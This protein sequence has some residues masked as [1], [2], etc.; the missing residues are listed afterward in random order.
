MSENLVMLICARRRGRKQAPVP[1]SQV[2]RCCECGSEVFVSP[3]SV[4]ILAK[5]HARPLCTLCVV[6]HRV[7]PDQIAPLSP[8]QLRE[9]I[10]HGPLAEPPA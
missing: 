1:G 4:A 7:R 5:R 10:E 3:S 2:R 9:I 8:A 6:R